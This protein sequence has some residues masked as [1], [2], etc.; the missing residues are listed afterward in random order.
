MGAKKKA[1]A[2]KKTG[3]TL[4]IV[5]SPAK[6]KTIGKFLGSEYEVHA[7]IGHVRDLPRKA[8]ELPAGAVKPKD[9]A[10]LGVDVAG[11]YEAIYIVPDDKKRQITELKKLM[12]SAPELLLAT[13][14]DREGESISWHLLEVLKPK[15]PVRRLVFHEITKGA[16]S[17]ALE[18]ARDIDANLVEAQESRRVLDRLFGYP[19]SSLLWR[20]IGR[21]RLSAGRVQSVTLRLLV[22]REKERLA[23]VPAEY[24]DVGAE[25]DALPDG[26]KFS[27]E[28]VQ[29]DGRKIA[30]GRHFDPNTGKLTSPDRVL[31]DGARAKRLAEELKDGT[32]TVQS[33]EEKPYTQRPA[34]PFTTSTLQQEAG[35][36]LR[37]A[38]Q[39][40]MRLAQR[41]Y[42]NGAITYMRTDSTTLS[43]QA[44]EAARQL[45]GGQ[46]GTE[47]LPDTPRVYKTKVKN[48][49]EAHEAIRPAGST[50][51]SIAD[52]KKEFGSEAGK[53]YEL[54]WKRTVASQ[55]KDAKG[56]R[57][58]VQVKLG[59]ALFR[60]SGSTIDFAGFRRAY[61]E[62]SDDP[63][64]ELAD[65][66]RVL[67]PLTE[68]QSIKALG[69]EAKEHWTQP[70]ARFTE[71]S[72][73]KE[74]DKRGIGR[75]STWASIIAKLLDREYCF[76]R[77]TALVPAY[78][79]FAV[80]RLLSEA[81]GEV[82]D[83]EFT[84]RMEDDLDSIAAGKLQ[85]VEYL[86]RFWEGNGKS[87]LAKLLGEAMEAVDPRQVCGFPVKDA[88]DDKLEIRVG[89]YGLFTTDGENRATL[90]EDIVPD[91]FTAAKA[92]EALEA[93]ARG[94][95]SLGKD[96]ESGLEVYCMV[97][98]FGPYVQLGEQEQ[99]GDKPKRESL[100]PGMT[101]ETMDLATA[102]KLLS[103]PK[104]LGAHPTMEGN[105]PVFA[106]NGRYGPYIKCGTETRSIPAE[107]PLL[108]ITL[109]QA[110]ELL[111]QPRRRGRQAQA[112]LKEVGKHP[113]S[114]ADMVIKS[115]RYGPY[116]TDGEVNAS[117]PKG[118]DPADV[119]LQDAVD[120]LER[121]RERIKAGGGVKKRKK[122]AA[123]KKK[124]AKKKAAKKK[125]AK[126]KTAKKKAAAKKPANPAPDADSTE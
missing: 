96:P 39:R 90:P 36:K 29:L 102:L 35:R 56:R 65:Q 16:I 33:V 89:R 75:P 57:M 4:V 122:K 14:E 18:S 25:L 53:L 92:L 67:P 49:Q 22:D 51:R 15:V 79:G 91:E 119:S 37:Y 94:P 78:L 126:K 86:R 30:S 6:A 42:E 2:K 118:K 73:V 95:T 68:G 111:A 97:G 20:K 1:S 103:F 13:D 8:S 59:D 106:Q 105:P 54:I 32:G 23:F 34:A 55:M 66:E 61:V 43:S 123:K 124:K 84:A 69:L 24:W 113:E 109:K 19:V 44:V 72:L 3:K 81:F 98:R 50:F 10:P 104:D 45:I 80:V 71:A 76:K 100:L 38:A 46:Y 116:V 114:G 115:G 11:G 112:T 58:T 31:V 99:G 87:G 125:S 48:A 62:G 5:E 83:F 107:I 74:L 26:G 60:A 93:A 12:R 17:R 70:P 64:K 77:G 27:A 88:S 82:M 21:Q 101:Q 121:R 47:Y 63:A 7:S 108:E 28:L 85:R 9:G 110:L 117:V 40:T 120:L 41:L 52:V